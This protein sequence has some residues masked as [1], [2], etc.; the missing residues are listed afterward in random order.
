[1]NA[2][3]TRDVVGPRRPRAPPIRQPRRLTAP[4]PRVKVRPEHPPIMAPPNRSSFA[5]TIGARPL[6]ARR[7]PLGLLLAALALPLPAAAQ[8]P[9][10]AADDV[11]RQ[12]PEPVE[13]APPASPATAEAQRLLHAGRFAEAA[14][15]Y[16]SAAA[17]SGDLPLTYHAGVARSLASHH[18]LALQHFT[19]CLERAASLG[20]PT[21]RHVAARQAAEQAQ[22]FPVRL[23]IIE[24]GGR[25]LP[26]AALA[27][28]R[29]SLQAAGYGPG[30]SAMLVLP[31]YRG[32]P[33]RVDPGAWTVR[34]EVP[35]YRPVEVLHTAASP[36][37]AVWEVAVAAQRVTVDLRFTPVQA[38]RGARLK[39]SPVPPTA[40]APVD[41]P[42]ESPSTSVVLPT[43]AWQVDVVA[44]RHESHFTV[45]VAPGMRPVE[46]TLHRRTRTDRPRF[47]RNQGLVGL[48]LTAALAEVLT[49]AA[50]SV[51]GGVKETRA[52][53]RNETLLLDSLV[54]AASARPG[55]PTGLAR[56]EAEYATAKYHHDLA[57]AHTLQNAGLIV[58]M[59]G[60][61]T[62]FA[63]VPVAAEARRRAAYV[64]L[65][66]GAGMLAGGSAWLATALRADRDLLAASAASER[67]TATDLRK[68]DGRRVG[69]ATLTGIG[70]GL[71]VFPAA[72][73]LTDSLVRRRAARRTARLA[74]FMAP[75][76]TGLAVHGRF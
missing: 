5:R 59:A 32:E 66:V 34:V 23:N 48:L 33:L 64:E 10:R 65:G 9:G 26:A 73:L 61:G 6:A 45:D 68:V 29:V 39:V 74:P 1:M 55:D 49:G 63:A 40:G 17:A 50:V 24:V 72:A 51:A 20:E 15:I 18:A 62:V 3:R 58:T 14:A 8:A 69:A 35:G 28:A 4:T 67:V 57:R 76:L 71:L 41:R 7:A 12:D 22:T 75:G 46:V 16:E 30:P 52:R 47:A 37:E 70:I 19:R 11:L 54:D 31:G 42:L 21:R 56:V 44:A 60:V 27:S 13:L 53:T 43:G 38:L 2:G 36:D 25:P